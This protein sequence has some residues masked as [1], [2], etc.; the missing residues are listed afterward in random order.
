MEAPNYWVHN[1][2][3]FL[4]QFTENFGI[5]YYGL[6]YALGFLSGMWLLHLFCKQIG[7][8]HV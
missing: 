2:D 8:A 4:L 5:R 6:A 7:R 3:P 1:L